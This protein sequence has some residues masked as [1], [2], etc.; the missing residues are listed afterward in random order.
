MGLAQSHPARRLR[1]KL[2]CAKGIRRWHVTVSVIE[3][4]LPLKK[5]FVAEV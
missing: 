1:I 4:S 2:A 5:R 3:H